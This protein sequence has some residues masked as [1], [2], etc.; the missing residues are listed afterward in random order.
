MEDLSKLKEVYDDLSGQ[1][2]GFSFWSAKEGENLIRVLP[3]VKGKSFYRELHYHNKLVDSQ[4]NVLCPKLTLGGDCPICEFR[5]KL[6]ATAKESDIDIIKLLKPY[7]RFY[8]NMVAVE[9]TSK[10]VM[11]YGMPMTV[12]RDMLSYFMDPDWG[13][14]TDP[15]NGYDVTIERRGTGLATKYFTRAKKKSTPVDNS[16]LS[17]II[18]LDELMHMKSYEELVDFLSALNSPG[19]N[20]EEEEP[21]EKEIEKEAEEVGESKP[22]CFKRLYNEED[23]ECVVCALKVE[24]K[25]GEKGV[26]TSGKGGSSDVQKKIEQKFAELRGKKIK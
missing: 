20:G 18:D 15:E 4:T 6:L 9:D 25:P 3:G 16:L 5:D 21:T 1:K 24:C 14:L 10:G 17:H 26:D 8:V 22:K 12:F 23:K 2:S 11:L 19:T 13:D 7:R